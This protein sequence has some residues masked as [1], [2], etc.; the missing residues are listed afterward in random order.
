M[1]ILL[2]NPIYLLIGPLFGVAAYEKHIAFPAKVRALIPS[3]IK[4]NGVVANDAG[5]AF[6]GGGACGGIAFKVS[7]KTLQAIKNEGLEFFAD[8]RPQ[9][10]ETYHTKVDYWRE[11][12]KTPIPPSDGGPMFIPNGCV[13]NIESYL[14]ENGKNLHVIPEGY[15]TYVTHRGASNLWVVPDWGIVVYSFYY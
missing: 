12:Q 5:F 7:Q 13:R 6:G 8:A 3:T 9:K 4:T 15:Y 1:I 10:A 2:L 11:W 14:K